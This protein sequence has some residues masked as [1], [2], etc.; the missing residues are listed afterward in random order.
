MSASREAPGGLENRDTYSASHTGHFLQKEAGL[1]PSLRTVYT[2]EIP[3]ELEVA[4]RHH[5]ETL[6]QG[7]D[8]IGSPQASKI[9]TLSLRLINLP[10]NSVGIQCPGSELPQRNQ[11]VVF[12][13]MLLD[14]RYQEGKARDINK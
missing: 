4:R 1:Q 11:R 2:G 14:S 3:P 10:G 12:Q 6:S 13:D 8:V 9:S 5:S 7:D